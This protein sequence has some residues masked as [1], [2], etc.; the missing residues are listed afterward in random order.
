[1]SRDLQFEPTMP[2]A[3]KTAREIYEEVKANPARA[4]FGFGEKLAIV[5]I[6]VQQAYTRPDLFPKSAYVTHPDQI[7]FI[8]RISRL[9]RA[10]G[11]PVIWTQVAYKPDGG[12]AG[13]VLPGDDHLAEQGLIDG[14]QAPGRPEGFEDTTLAQGGNAATPVIRINACTY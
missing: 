12:D 10:C 1:M 9:A 8:N 4:R 5:N 13:V 7:D 2:C 14:V 11:M 3:G 6:D